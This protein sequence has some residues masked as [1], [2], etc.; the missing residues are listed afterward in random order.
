MIE[1]FRN[2]VDRFKEWQAA[3]AP[4][5]LGMGH[6]SEWESNYPSWENLWNAT[7]GIIDG[8]SRLDDDTIDALLFVLARDNEDER[9][10]D[11]LAETPEV[12]IRILPAALEY[13]D[14][15]ARWQ[16]AMLLPAALGERARLPL[17]RLMHDPDDYVRRRAAAALQQLDA[18]VGT[19]RPDASG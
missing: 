17:R 7:R 9:V 11:M 19:A 4:D 15:D 3:G 1:R 18:A 14:D 5:L 6:G 10:A 13:P 8:A 2:E 16:I 12:V